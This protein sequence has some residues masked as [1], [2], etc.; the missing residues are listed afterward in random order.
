[1]HVIGAGLPRTGTLSQKAA[2]ETLGLGPCYHWVDVI[3]D[4]N[5]V[6]QWDRALDGDVDWDEIFTAFNST[7][8]WP[9]GHFFRE[10]TVAYPEAKVVLST[11]EPEPW[12]QSFRDTIWSLCFGESLTRL[13]ASARAQVDPHDDRDH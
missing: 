5:R 2:L 7:V 1:M 12:E 9:G 10:L 11:R 4:L 3:A 8:D 13:L 6:G